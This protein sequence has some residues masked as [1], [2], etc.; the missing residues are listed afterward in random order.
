MSIILDKGRFKLIYEPENKSKTNYTLSKKTIKNQ[1]QIKQ[2]TH[3][4]KTY[5]GLSPN[6]NTSKKKP[7][8]KGYNNSTLYQGHN[9][10]YTNKKNISTNKLKYNRSFEGGLLKNE[11]IENNNDNKIN[12][13]LN[14]VINNKQKNKSNSKM[15]KTSIFS[16]GNKSKTNNQIN[17]KTNNNIIK[18]L[19]EKF[20]SLENN[21]IDKK[22]ENDIDH[23]EIIITADRKTDDISKS[24]ESKN[25]INYLYNIINNNY[26]IDE[27]LL[28]SSFENNKNDFKIMYVENYSNTIPSDMLI[29]E[30][31]LIFEKILEL[32]KSYH[33]EINTIL[34]HYFIYK[35]EY[36]NIINIYNIIQKKIILLHKIN[37]K[38]NRKENQNCFNIYN[39]RNFQELNDINNNEVKIWKL[40]MNSEDN[41]NIMKAKKDKL[42]EIFKKSVF[43]KFNKIKNLNLSDIEKKIIINLMKKNKYVYVPQ[44]ESEINK[45]KNNKS[46]NILKKYSNKKILSPITPNKNMSY[47]SNGKFKHKKMVSHHQYKG[48]KY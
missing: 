42:K 2:Q 44:S 34:Y 39:K 40:M 4:L 38:N 18:K 29:L 46:N 11:L 24:N 32:Q 1:S 23:D 16:S 48:K 20:K 3:L 5:I 25:N 9:H 43:D 22:Y 35:N 14:S 21:I 26:N 30:L 45:I 41:E 10:K 8:I 12:K 7:F 36:K 19:D 31:K 37:E 28:N 27:N 17:N 47:L 33:N 6:N 15:N 13:N